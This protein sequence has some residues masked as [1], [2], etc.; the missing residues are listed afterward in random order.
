[1]FDQYDDKNLGQLY[2]FSTIIELPEFVKTASVSDLDNIKSIPSTS[3]ADPINRKYPIHTKSDTYMSRLYF[4]KN[5]DMYKSASYRDKVSDS[6]GKAAKFWRLEDSYRKMPEKTAA[7]KREIPIEDYTGNTIDTIV[8]NSP[9]DFEK[10][11]IQIFENKN[12][13]NFS[14]RNKISK[15][16]LGCPFRKE[17]KLSDATSEYLHKAAGRGLCTKGQLLDAIHDRAALYNSK[18]A[19]YSEQ[20]AELADKT[21]SEEVTPELLEKVAGVFDFCDTEL[22]FSKFYS[23]GLLDSPE[24][25]LFQMTEKQASEIKSQY[26]RLING[27]TLEMSKLSEEQVDKFFTDYMGEIPAG[28]LTEKI[29][30]IRTLPAPDADALVNFLG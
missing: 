20:M 29:A 1:M 28:D 13:F 12:L 24:D 23:N 30:V 25:T 11:A 9:R 16:L 15:S 21:A 14:Q 26:V 7:L 19:F 4:S 22:G 5:Q 10:A 8:L 3:F 18:D 2:R 6:L 17:A 27:K